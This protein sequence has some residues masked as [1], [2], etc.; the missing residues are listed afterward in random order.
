MKNKE[1]LVYIQSS[2]GGTMDRQMT[3][4]DIKQHYP[5]QW[6]SLDLPPG[7]TLK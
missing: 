1:V 7:T 5:D 3:W 6:V 4:E 2:I